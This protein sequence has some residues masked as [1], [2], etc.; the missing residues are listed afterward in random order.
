V[1]IR[2]FGYELEQDIE[3][4]AILNALIERVLQTHRKTIALLDRVEAKMDDTHAQIEAHRRQDA[5]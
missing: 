1:T 2:N 4:E 5:Q 3:D